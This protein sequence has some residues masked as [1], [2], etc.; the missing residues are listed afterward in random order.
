MVSHSIL[1]FLCFSVAISL[2]LH[3][4]M[5]AKRKF[6]TLEDRVKVLELVG[7]GDSVR[8]IAANV[9]KCYEKSYIMAWSMDLVIWLKVS[10]KPMKSTKKTPS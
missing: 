10:P 4:A 2:H 9:T 8:A 5:S 6:L 1:I 7:K 3:F